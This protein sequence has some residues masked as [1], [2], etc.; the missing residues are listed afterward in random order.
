MKGC[1]VTREM[2]Q[3][4]TVNQSSKGSSNVGS[5]SGNANSGGS[6][7]HAVKPLSTHKLNVGECCLHEIS[8]MH[9]VEGEEA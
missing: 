1:E 6:S 2:H 7:L 9:G 4:E 3:I 8:I 5:G